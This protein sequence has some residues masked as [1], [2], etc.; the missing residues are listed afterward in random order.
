M[1]HATQKS[2]G[3][4]QVENAIALGARRVHGGEGYE[5]NSFM[6]TILADLDH[7]VEIM[8]DETF[9]PAACIMRFRSDDEEVELA[10]DTPFGLG[11]AAFGEDEERAGNLAR[12]LT[13]GMIGINKGR[14]GAENTP[15]V[16]AKQSGY[17]YHT[18]KEGHRQ[19][20]HVRLVSSVKPG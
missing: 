10:N 14:G 15:W 16:G 2:R 20:A 11:A 5:G 7:G 17:G 4:A 6:P 18:A 13:A 1:T 19:F 3:V 12:R 9:G 8:R